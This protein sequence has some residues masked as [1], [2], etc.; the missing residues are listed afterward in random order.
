[1]V[2]V[3]LNR[4]EIRREKLKWNPKDT[5]TIKGQPHSLVSVTSKKKMENIKKRSGRPK[6]LAVTY[7]KKQYRAFPI[8]DGKKGIKKLNEGGQINQNDIDSHN[9]FALEM[10]AE[11]ISP[12]L[13]R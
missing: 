9:R 12:N 7:Q 3:F 8:G 4:N 6:G 13:P 11:R 5:K 2:K 10:N 1:M